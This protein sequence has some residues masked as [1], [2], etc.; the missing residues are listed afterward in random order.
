MAITSRRPV[1][2]VGVVAITQN[3]NRA[4]DKLA[5][6]VRRE[7]VRTG[8]VEGIVETRSPPRLF[9]ARDGIQELLQVGG[10]C[11]PNLNVA[12]ERR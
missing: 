9:E 10:R 3:H 4:M 2:A 6:A 12:A 1:Q 5:L 8:G 7:L 11:L